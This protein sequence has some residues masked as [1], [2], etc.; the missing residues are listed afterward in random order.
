M[1][2]F[3]ILALPLALAAQPADNEK[4]TQALISEIQQLRLAIERST[5]LGART[6]LAI[7]QQQVQETAIAR[8]ASQ[9]N[10]VRTQA[11]GLAGHR[12]R[13][14]ESIRQAEEQRTSPDY[15][16]GVRKTQVEME[17]KQYKMELDQANT[18]ELG[19]SARESELTSQLQAAQAQIADSRA[20]IA[21]LERALDAA[22]QQLLKPPAP[23]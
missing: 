15:A 3:A 2:Y 5:L 4:V 1:R 7:S 14:T 8:I 13:L 6:Q 10:D 21:D 12:T 9:L 11:T 19:R 22:I 17:L 20:R 23:R 18:I 16:S